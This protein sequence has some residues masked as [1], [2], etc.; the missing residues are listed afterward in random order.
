[1]ILSPVV[2]SACWPGG[3]WWGVGREGEW[4]TVMKVC[5][6]SY[7]PGGEGRGGEESGNTVMKVCTVGYRP[8]GEG[9][10]VGTLS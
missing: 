5:T 9:R 4:N 10:R 3:W 2:G 6:V 1:M 7:R 8:G